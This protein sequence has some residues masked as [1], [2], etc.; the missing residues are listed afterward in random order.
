[1]GRKKLARSSENQE[2]I[3]SLIGFNNKMS[4]R[5]LAF[6]TDIKKSS[7][8]RILKKH[9]RLRAYKPRLSQK[10]KEGDDKKRL[11]FCQK[12]E[13]LIQ[14]DELDPSEIIFSDESHIYLKGS[15]NKQKNRK[16]GISRPENRTA[17]P[18][19]SAKV[20]IWCGLK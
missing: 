12:I 18:L 5:R 16:W 11:D 8:H 13:E 14:N 3:Q 15:P 9:L 19:L 2:R 20:P 10:L 7:V 6:A 17:V 1:M 4:V